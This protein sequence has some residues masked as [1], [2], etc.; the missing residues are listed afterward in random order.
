MEHKKLYEIAHSRHGQVGQDVVHDLVVKFGEHCP[1]DAYLTKCVRTSKPEPMQQSFEYDVL[2]EDEVGEDIWAD[3]DID[4]I[5][6]I[7]E[8]LRTKYEEEIDTFLECKVNGDMKSF[9][10][11]SGV[12]RTTLEKICNFVKYEILNEYNRRRQ[13]DS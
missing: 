10:K 4:M 13:F 5:M 1:N 8:F 11:H 12:S 2:Q 7:I 6:S 9:Q 3:T